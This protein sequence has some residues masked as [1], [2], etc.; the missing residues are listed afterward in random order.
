[1]ATRS[2]RLSLVVGFGLLGLLVAVGTVVPPS[3]D[4][5][6]AVSRFG[7]RVTLLPEGFSLSL[8]PLASRVTLPRREGHAVI[9]TT[10]VAAGGGGAPASIPVRIELAGSG[11][12]PVDADDV[13]RFGLQEAWHRWL[14]GRLDLTPDQL[15]A[16][17]ASTPLWREIFPPGEERPAPSNLGSALETALRPLAVARFE[18]GAQIDPEVVRAAARRTLA[19][20]PVPR[21]RLVLLGL[22]ALD[23][24]LVDQLTAQG[25]MPNLRGLLR[26]GTQAVHD[27][28]PPL[29][30]P[31]VWNTI[32]TGVP[33]EVHGVLDFL[34]PDPGG[35]APRPVTS[36]SRKAPAIWEMAALAGR[37]TAVIGWWA[38]FPA[39]APPGGA[40]YSDRLTEQ[41]LS[42]SAETP[43]LADPPAAE[44]GARE[45][46]VRA[47]DVTE[48]MLA[49]FAPVS[50]DEL[51]AATSRS[52]AWDEPVGGLVKLVAATR[53][54][55]NLTDRELARG[56][57]IVFSYLEGTDIVGHLFGP[58]R[59]PAMRGADPALV[60]RFGSVVDRYHAS[61]DAWIGRIAAR[62][63]P[64]DTLVI[65][66]DHGFA[67][68]EERPHAPSG[69]HTA[70]ATLWH[71]PQGVFIAVGPHVRASA[72][73][74]RL[75]VLE[76]GPSLL[77]MAGLAPSAEM[78]GRVPAWLMASPG[79]TLAPVRYSALVSPRSSAVELSP[80]A[81]QEA[82]A[83]LRALGY[84][85]GPGAPA[86][87][88][89]DPATAPPPTAAPTRAFD[90]AEARRLNNLAISQAS[91]GEREKAEG[92]FKKAIAADPTYAPPYYSYS[93]MLR[94]QLRLEEADQLFWTAVRLGVQ[95]GELAVV[96][97]ALDYEA[98]GMP[99]KGRDVLAEGRRLFPESATIWLNSGVF[100]GDQGD[101]NG[102]V[103][104]LRRATQ[105][106]PG[107]VAAHRNLA[108]ALIGLG[109]KEEAR[110]ALAHVLALD[111]S[112]AA[113]R[114]QL[115][116]LG[117]RPQ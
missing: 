66:S 33:P 105:L 93:T 85:A 62:L 90:R 10:L 44:A 104:C 64:E 9:E 78:P 26:R 74:R 56:T 110:R 75:G 43:G 53:T 36:A 16:A 102:A 58:F 1:M 34:E 95:E 92:N 30:S 59:P 107:N 80:E 100:L 111:P 88:V 47:R 116:A 2:R 81:R 89:P 29:I 60:R 31:V 22:D 40:V 17:V 63:G 65:V 76:V 3:R 57:S 99:A 24:Q 114:Q 54:V 96:R 83:K 86:S 49:Q 13:R 21:G 117:G 82:L 14:A 6:V 115:E 5:V 70:T 113:A 50:R 35:G 108:V 37:T 71:R 11:R 101:L 51:A 98:R 39:A 15:Q 48:A 84:I 20:G 19:S 94:R 23:W 55:E 109:E 28:P 91:E 12:M 112:D 46:A 45:L 97:L 4:A 18:I 68:G 69:T 67:W 42:L 103:A 87:P 8:L 61:V 32:G 27:V 25:V 7:S 41:L 79:P 73:R 106:A 38:T 52:D 77:A 72:T